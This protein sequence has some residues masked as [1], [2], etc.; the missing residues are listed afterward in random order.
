MSSKNSIRGF[1]FHC[2]IDLHPQP[3]ETISRCA[4]EGIVTVAVTTTP[5]AWPQNATWTKSCPFVHAATG[6]HPE[7]VGDRF[8]EVNLL[9]SQIQVSRLVGE[10]GLDGS[11]QHRKSYERQK[12]VFRRVLE[13]SRRL[14]GRVLTIHSRRASRDAVSMIEEHS[15]T[16]RTLCVLHWFSGSVEEAR[17]ALDAGCYFSI[18][19][20]MLIHERGQKLVQSLPA[21]RLLTESDAPFSVIEEC[22]IE[23]WDA[24]KTAAKLAEILQIPRAEM[25]AA[26]L[27]NSRRVLRFA[28][29]SLPDI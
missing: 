11:P 9:E 15:D 21:D 24:T 26:L 18:N 1:D 14:D 28:G 17:R 25:G 22:D 23:P 3:T 8:H 19:P 5:K 20:A 7:L 10:V 12:E 2:H 13:L 27:D 29:I 6:L 4:Q 16:R